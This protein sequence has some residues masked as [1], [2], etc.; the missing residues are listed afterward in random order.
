MS[1]VPSYVVGDNS[2]T[3]PTPTTVGGVSMFPRPRPQCVE[4]ECVEP[5]SF[6][7]PG[8]FLKMWPT[9]RASTNIHIQ[10][11]YTLSRRSIPSARDHWARNTYTLHTILQRKISSG[12]QRMV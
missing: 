6:M 10:E 5:D 1:G 7:S 8:S 3:L 4:P 9:F 2:V 12:C 11:N